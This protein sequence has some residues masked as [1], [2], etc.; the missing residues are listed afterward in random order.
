[1]KEILIIAARA[2]EKTPEKM[3][4]FIIGF[5]SIVLAFEVGFLGA[6]AFLIVLCS[7]YV[8]IR[9]QIILENSDKRK[10]KI[11]RESLRLQQKYLDYKTGSQ[12]KK[13]DKND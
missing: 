13:E 12:R 4:F 5:L 2:L 3:F 9:K 1:M 10:Y 8:Y 7:Y 6:M 11:D